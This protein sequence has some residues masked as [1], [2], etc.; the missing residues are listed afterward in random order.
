MDPAQRIVTR[1]PLTE[2]WTDRGP[3]N[4]ERERLVGRSDLVALLQA[5]PVQFIVADVGHS[6]RWVPQTEYLLAW[7]AD[8]R[9]HL[10]DEPEGPIDIYQYPEGYAYVASEWAAEGVHPVPL[11]LL[12]R[13]H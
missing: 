7:K 8:V 6:L 2:L 9:S 3:I 4:A 13:H 12:E 5:G 11:V 10:V 1:L